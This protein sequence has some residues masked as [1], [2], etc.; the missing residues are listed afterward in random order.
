M[1]KQEWYLEFVDYKHKPAKDEIL[2]KF[3]VEPAKGMPEKEA[4]GRVASE[5]SCGTWTTL[6][7]LPARL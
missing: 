2:V 7:K 5:S 4:Y 1:G 3:Y 6:A